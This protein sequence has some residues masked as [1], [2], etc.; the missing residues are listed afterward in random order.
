MDY[1][2][3]NG[4]DIAKYLRTKTDNE[5]ELLASSS[6]TIYIFIARNNKILKLKDSVHYFQWIEDDSIN[7]YLKFINQ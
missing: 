2:F 1:N 4:N 5:F 3:K 6:K 7:K